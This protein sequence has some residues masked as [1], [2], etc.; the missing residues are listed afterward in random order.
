LVTGLAARVTWGF[1]GPRHAQFRD[2]WH[3]RS[4]LDI[5]RRPR[6]PVSHRFGHNEYASLVYLA[7]YALLAIMGVT[8]LA[9]AAIAHDVGPLVALLGTRQVPEDLVGEPHE[10]IAT[11]L[12]LFVAAHLVALIVHERLE[13]NRTAR[14]M[15]TGVQFR[16]RAEA[17]HG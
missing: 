7:V 10:F 15:L 1:V 17:R 11:L 3:P 13:S 2:L 16:R 8:G 9:L 5:L 4:W 6:L 12:A 14:S